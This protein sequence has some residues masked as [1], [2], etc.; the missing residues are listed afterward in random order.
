MASHGYLGH[1]GGESMIEF[2]VKNCSISEE[3]IKN[4]KVAFFPSFFLSFLP[5]S[6]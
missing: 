5:A 4:F 3:E 1:E 2:V 6:N